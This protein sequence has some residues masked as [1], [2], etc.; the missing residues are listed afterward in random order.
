MRKFFVLPTALLVFVL[1]SCNNYGKKVKIDD[2]MEVYLKGD[3]VTENQAKKLG[4]YLV[5]L[6]KESKNQKSLQLSKDSGM[7]VVRMVVDENKLKKDTTVDLG[8]AALK[9]LLQSQVFDNQPVKF[10][11]ADDTFDDIKSY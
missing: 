8:F 7:F 11:L 6:W 10:I 4:S 3:G 2:T 9:T 1:I 5:N